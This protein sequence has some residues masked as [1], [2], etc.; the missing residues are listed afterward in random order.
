MRPN[1]QEMLKRVFQVDIKKTL[2]SNMITCEY[3]K[4][5]SKI[6]RIDPDRNFITITVME[7][8][9]LIPV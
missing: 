1:L 6:K 4:L 2:N 3:M 9:L 8:S 7:K 5:I